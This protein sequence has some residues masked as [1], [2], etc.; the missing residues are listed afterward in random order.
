M[1][2]H[3]YWQELLSA[4]VD[5]EL[6][7]EEDEALQAHLE[8]CEKCRSAL[9][10]LRGMTAVLGS[11]EAEPPSALPEGARFLF[12]RER[13]EGRFSW[14]RWRFTAIA[15]VVCI[16]LLGFG[17]Q[18][19]KLF[20]GGMKA[21]APAAPAEYTMYVLNDAAEAAE[22]ETLTISEQKTAVLQASGVTGAAP[23]PVPAPQATAAAASGDEGVHG[24]TESGGAREEPETP[25]EERSGNYSCRDSVLYTAE[26]LPGYAIY[27]SLENGEKWYSVCFV[28]GEVPQS[29]REDREC[30]PMEAPEGQERW[31]VPLSVCLNEGLREQFN[32]IYYGDLLAEY[33]LVIGITD[34]EEEK[35]L[36]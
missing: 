11:E 31:Q 14:K 2:D 12:Q 34:M 10:L 8:G 17:T 9:A 18:V 19:P 27:Q 29:I 26:G 21:A 32:E 1:E 15:A 13:T 28:Y 16:A 4:Y 36:P 7:P 25:G 33:G 23:T 3:G 24:S 22:T 5:G 35:W 6:T 20:G 30:V